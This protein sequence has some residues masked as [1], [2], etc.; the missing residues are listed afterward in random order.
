MWLWCVY[1][2]F[3]LS[4]CMK[5]ML[6]PQC[7]SRHLSQINWNYVGTRQ[8]KITNWFFFS[9]SLSVFRVFC[10]SFGWNSFLWLLCVALNWLLTFF[11]SFCSKLLLFSVEFGEFSEITMLFMLRTRVSQFHFQ[12]HAFDPTVDFM[13]LLTNGH[14]IIKTKLSN[15]LNRS[16]LFLNK[17]FFFCIWCDINPVNCLYSPSLWR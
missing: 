10:Y 6:L 14:K 16:H 3:F 5:E 12:Q 15:D 7:E 2:R 17:S 1:V 8:P 11:F 9:S 13:P 4:L